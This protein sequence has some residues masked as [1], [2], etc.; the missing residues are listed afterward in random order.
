MISLLNVV[1]NPQECEGK[2]D[3]ITPDKLSAITN[4]YVKRI[5]CICLDGFSFSDR[6]NLLQA[7]VQKLC[8]EGELSVKFINLNLLAN[9]I[10]SEHLNGEKYSKILPSI[11][12]A[13]TDDEAM[14]IIKQLP[15]V[16]SGLYY[17]NFY[18][19]INMEK[20]G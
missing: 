1:D 8:L 16:I 9:K 13:W 19:I 3:Y 10:Q 17:E 20:T 18:S 12:S 11:R 5:N 7:M 4:N 2:N 6:I 15:V 14:S